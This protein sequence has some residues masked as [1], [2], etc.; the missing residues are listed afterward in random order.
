MDNIC[1]CNREKSYKEALEAISALIDGDSFFRAAQFQRARSIADKA[2]KCKCEPEEEK[3]P[4]CPL[5]FRLEGQECLGE[6]CE[7]WDD[8]LGACSV[9]SI[10]QGLGNGQ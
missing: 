9:F 1:K 7:W 6:K 2:L 5:R 4:R 3:L 10:A 8:I